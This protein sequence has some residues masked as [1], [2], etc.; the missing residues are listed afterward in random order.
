MPQT[1]Y[2]RA[3]RKPYP[4]NG[5]VKHKPGPALSF[6]HPSQNE[7]KI[8]LL[9]KIH[10]LSL[11]LPWQTGT[12]IPVKRSLIRRQGTGMENLRHVFNKNKQSLCFAVKTKD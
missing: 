6:K 7:K 11:G 12:Y 4:K 10:I 5:E 2:Q 9:A 3:F 1:L 8:P